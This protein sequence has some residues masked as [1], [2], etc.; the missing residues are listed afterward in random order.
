MRETYRSKSDEC[1]YYLHDAHINKISA[2]KNNIK[3]I[4][5]NGY[6]VKG[7]E[8][9]IPVKGY[10]EFQDVDHDFCRVYILNNIK[11]TGKFN[12]KKYWLKKFSNKHKKVDMEIIDETYYHNISKFTGWIYGKNKIW[13]FIIEIY[14]FGSMIYHT[15]D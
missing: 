6:F 11:D 10:I 5:G 4:F 7:S 12:G 13:E 14:H 8:D 2:G 3:F 15:E 9:C 1:P